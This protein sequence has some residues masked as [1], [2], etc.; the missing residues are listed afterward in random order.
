MKKL[1]AAFAILILIALTIIYS[2]SLF[3]KPSET[4]SP[5]QT[6]QANQKSQTTQ[7]TSNSNTQDTTS[8]TSSSSSSSSSGSSGSSGGSGSGSSSSS[9]DTSSQNCRLEQI[10]YALKN[11]IS[12]STCNLYQ[13]EVCIDKTTTCF[14]N[15]QN[16]DQEVSGEF[17][18]RF[19]FLEQ[20]EIYFTTT[21][22]KTVQANSIEPFQHSLQLQDQEAQ[23]NIGC[24]SNTLK[25]PKKE[26][27]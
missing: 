18:I 16:L 15:V 21:Q 17:E 8:I 9:D 27:C 25:V 10:S 12:N 14:V 6:Q 1:L 24:T 23:K 19:T 2:I 11:F 5:T 26:V 7:D 4:P 3:N 20:G 22:T 13:D